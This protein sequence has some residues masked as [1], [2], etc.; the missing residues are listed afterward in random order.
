[1][2]FDG[3]HT[4]GV[5]AGIHGSYTAEFL[6]A[7]LTGILPGNPVIPIIGTLVLLGVLYWIV[8]RQF[9]AADFIQFTRTR[10][11][12]AEYSTGLNP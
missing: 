7:H 12:S 10:V 9:E 6:A 5:R 1:M 8:Q 2:S 3:V 4:K 11:D